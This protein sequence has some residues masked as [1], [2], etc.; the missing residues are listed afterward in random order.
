MKVR[1][2]KGDKGKTFNRSNS[3]ISK[4]S[5]L[6]SALGDID[7][8]SAHLGLLKVRMPSRTAAGIVSELQKGLAVIMAVISG[9]DASSFEKK[10]CAQ[11]CSWIE[12]VICNFERELKGRGCFYVPGENELS[13]M[14]DISRAVARR[15]ERSVVGFFMKNK[16]TRPDKNILKF[17]NCISD[18]LFIL[19][20]SEIEKKG[21]K[22]RKG[23]KRT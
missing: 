6:I 20:V 17:M 10:A 7:E 13:A 5:P 2:S 18:I 11:Y 14:I 12:D 21:K 19:A 9:E 4:C 3:E 16:N 1:T 15:A 22:D 23:P 8:L